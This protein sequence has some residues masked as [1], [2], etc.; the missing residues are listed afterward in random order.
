MNLTSEVKVSKRYFYIK[1]PSSE[2]AYLHYEIKDNVME[3]LETYT[4]PAYRG[5]GLAAK[6]TSYA[7]EYAKEKGLR[8]KPIC[9]YAIWFFIKHPEYKSLLVDEYRNIDLEELYR[10]R[11]SEEKA[12]K[13]K[14]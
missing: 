10:Q 3:L 7:L 8:V 4:P 13:V 14:Q 6:I 5:K 9:S 12:K 1:L 2:K 11:I